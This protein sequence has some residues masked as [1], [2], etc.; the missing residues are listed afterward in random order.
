M[1]KGIP[2]YEVDPAE[3]ARRLAIPPLQDDPKKKELQDPTLCRLV[4]LY[5][6]ATLS[7]EQKNACAKVI[8]DRDEQNKWAAAFIENIEASERKNLL[9]EYEN[10][11]ILCKEKRTELSKLQEQIEILDHR[12]RDMEAKGNAYQKAC[13]RLK[14]AESEL[15]TLD[16][17][18]SQKE[19]RAAHQAIADAQL[20]VD[21][22]EEKINLAVAHYN[23]LV[24]QVLPPVRAE[25]ERVTQKEYE[26]RSKLEGSEYTDTDGILH[27]GTRPTP[28]LT[29]GSL[30][31]SR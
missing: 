3:F 11:K 22:A 17:Y 19:I 18:S 12:I 13:T 21:A 7:P 25:F 1:Q 15:E 26:L 30:K 8:F 23:R 29:G 31:R 5:S 10:V 16:K 28:I 2:V 6:H 20:E 9:S 24:Q 14:N 4:E 27:P